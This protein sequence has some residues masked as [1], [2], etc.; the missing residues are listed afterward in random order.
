MFS[1]ENIESLHQVIDP[2]KNIEKYILYIEEWFNR[3]EE[4]DQN[5]PLAVVSPD[6]YHGSTLLSHWIKFHEERDIKPNKDII[7]SHFSIKNQVENEYCYCIFKIVSQIKSLFNV[8]TRIQTDEEKLRMFFSYWLDIASQKISQVLFSLNQQQNQ[9]HFLSFF[10]SEISDQMKIILVIDSIDFLIDGSE[11]KIVHTFLWF[12]KIFPKQFK[13]IVSCSSSHTD[14]VQNY[15]SQGVTLLKVDSCIHSLLSHFDQ[16]QMEYMHPRLRESLKQYEKLKPNIR[17]DLGCIMAYKT[18]FLNSLE[19]LTN[20]EEGVDKIELYFEKID[21]SMANQFY[22]AQSFIDFCIKITMNRIPEIAP[23][24]SYETV[25]KILGVLQATNKGLNTQEVAEATETDEQICSSVINIFSP[26]L[27]NNDGYY[28][29]Y[30]DQIREYICNLQ[31]SQQKN[32]YSSLIMKFLHKQHFNIKKMHELFY[33]AKLSELWFKLKDYLTQIDN[34]ILYYSYDEN[35]YTIYRFWVLIE[36]NGLD[37]IQEYVRSIEEYIVMHSPSDEDLFKIFFQISLFFYEFNEFEAYHTPEFRHPIIKGNFIL[38][39]LGMLVEMKKL[40]MVCDNEENQNDFE[41]KAEPYSLEGLNVDIPKSRELA[42]QKL[43]NLAFELLSDNSKE[44]ISRYITPDQLEQYIQPEL[45]RVYNIQGIKKLIELIKELLKNYT[46]KQTKKETSKTLFSSSRSVKPSHQSQYY[47]KR[48]LWVYF[49]IASMNNKISYSDLMSVFSKYQFNAEADDLE[50]KY[51][52]EALQVILNMK[53]KM[54]DNCNSQKKTQASTFYK[55]S[56]Q[57]TNNKSIFQKQQTIMYQN[58]QTLQQNSVQ[59]QNLFPQNSQ[60]PQNS[61]FLNQTQNAENNLTQPSLSTKNTTFQENFSIKV[62][63]YPSNSQKIQTEPNLT[64]SQTTTSSFFNNSKLRTNYQCIQ[65][66]ILFSFFYFSQFQMIKKYS[67]FFDEKTNLYKKLKKFFL[68]KFLKEFGKTIGIGRS[69]SPHAQSANKNVIFMET[70]IFESEL[71]SD[72]SFSSQMLQK[73]N[74]NQDSQFKRQQSMKKNNMQTTAQQFNIKRQMTFEKL[75]KSEN[76]LGSILEQPS[77]PKLLPILRKNTMVQNEQSPDP[78]EKTNQNQS[79]LNQ[80]SITTKSFFKSKSP[81]RTNLQS[82]QESISKAIIATVKQTENKDIIILPKLKEQLN[83][84][85][86]KELEFLQKQNQLMQKEYD[87]LVY[88][89]M[90]LA[91]QLKVI[92]KMDA[93][94]PNSNLIEESKDSLQKMQE[95]IEKM[96]ERLNENQ[97]QCARINNIISICYRNKITNAENLNIFNSQ[98]QNLTKMENYERDLA[99]DIQDRN[100]NFVRMNHECLKILQER[101][102]NHESIII[103]IKNSFQMKSKINDMMDKGIFLFKFISHYNLFIY[104]SLFDI[105]DQVIK[106]EDDNHSLHNKLEMQSFKDKQLK[107]TSIQKKINQKIQN[108]QKEIDQIEEAIYPLK[109]DDTFYESKQYKVFLEKQEKKNRLKFLISTQ[110][111][112]IE[113]LKVQLQCSTNQINLLKKALGENKKFQNSQS[114]SSNQ[115]YEQEETIKL[116]DRP[117]YELKQ[118]KDQL[119]EQLQI[120]L[121]Q[122]RIYQSSMLLCLL[123]LNNSYKTCGIFRNYGA[124]SIKLPSHFSFAELTKDLIDK[125]KF[126]KAHLL[127][128]QYEQYILGKIDVQDI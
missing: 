128:E 12:P 57:Q 51:R 106:N 76:D 100:A 84:S 105:A 113:Q 92:Q 49:T 39:E 121:K 91:K 109:F 112:E 20:F 72:S 97:A 43:F 114:T 80:K 93:N 127:P 68:L 126:I 74:T 102:H 45:S 31:D 19:Y 14:L 9:V 77:S 111:E 55:S 78:L 90:N 71:K 1:K 62:V 2:V 50:K 21:I 5:K 73:N 107:L 40:K 70:S 24:I 8:K 16:S 88:E 17:N 119:A 32:F 75:Q 64:A 27:L 82:L 4:N 38:E 122:N 30:F 123:S 61:T 29:I 13:V 69:L 33:Q 87:S 96:T 99:K 108:L 118:L 22:Q 53:Q 117:I 95:R 25:K 44:K 58:T 42:K 65:I 116:E 37:P 11:E 66:S 85:T 101:I 115:D 79:Q 67:L 94:Y 48:W 35:K 47:Y 83:I 18:A 52:D 56:Q 110:L 81:E 54:L 120:D 36:A 41:I 3:K 60:F 6:I 59:S 28:K 7:I 86:D 26:I 98:L 23:N 46:Q 89:N 124:G 34:F 15:Q 63:Q 103:Q 10:S 125:D 104:V